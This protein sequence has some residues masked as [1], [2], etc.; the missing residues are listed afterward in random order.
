MKS[1]SAEER[2]KGNTW[3]GSKA[4]I[5]PDDKETMGILRVVCKAGCT[6]DKYEKEFN[7]WIVSLCKSQ[8]HDVQ[9]D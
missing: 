1:S 3:V 5:D 4:Y 9:E 6:V 7:E 8:L 2:G